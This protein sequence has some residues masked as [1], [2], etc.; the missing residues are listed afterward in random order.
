MQA[1]E[2]RTGVWDRRRVLALAPDD[3]ARRAASQ[4][5]TTSWQ[6]PGRVAGSLLWGRCRGSGSRPYEVVVDPQGPAYGCSCPSRKSPCKHA[7]ALLL[8]W[9][10]GQVPEAPPTGYAERWNAGRAGSVAAEPARPAGTLVDPGA[11]A[12][13]T[14]AREQ[15]VRDGLEELAVWLG[16]QLR[17]GLAAMER[18]GYAAVETVAARMVDAQAPGVASLLRSLP[19]ELNTEGWPGRVLEQ[20][21]ALHLLV[22]AHRRLADLPV[23][24]AATVRSRIGYPV[25]RA[26][27]LTGPGVDDD[28]WAVGQLDA[29]EGRLETRRVW[30]WGQ[31]S[32]RWALWLS[33]VVPGQ[34]P[35]STVTAG[36]RLHGQLHYYPGSGQFRAVVGERRT[37]AGGDGSPGSGPPTLPPPETISAARDRFAALLAADPWASRMPAVLRVAPVPPVAD[38]PWRLRDRDGWCRDVLGGGAEPWSLLAESGGREVAVMVEWT[39][40]GVRPLAVLDGVRAAV[41][42]VR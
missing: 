7:L 29:L 34:A 1:V 6:Q 36:E 30:L 27:V 16:D 22:E 38:E 21:S 5:P 41:R 24:L 28:W 26:E 42:P 31:H 32:R 25:T 19:A 12:A 14:A 2:Q 37:P 13:R 40:G 8:R 4:V 17:G 35:D 18:T 9:I 33:F 11:A 3:A 20:L 23:D 15:R 39:A 10:D